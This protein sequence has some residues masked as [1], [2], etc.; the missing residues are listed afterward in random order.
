VHELRVIKLNYSRSYDLKA[1]CL[2]IV[3]WKMKLIIAF[4]EFIPPSGGHQS[5]TE[6]KK[7]LVDF[8]S[9]NM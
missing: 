8:C 6:M 5:A 4:V 1:H 2:T 3:G 7:L 9:K